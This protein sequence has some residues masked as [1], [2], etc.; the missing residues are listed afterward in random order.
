MLA[1]L[2]KAA[3]VNENEGCQSIRKADDGD[4]FIVG[5]VR[6][7]ENESATYHARRIVLALGNRGTP[8][9][10][11]VP[12]E[13]LKLKRD[14]A[15]R[16]K[17]QYKLI[18]PEAYRGQKILVVGAGNSAIEAAV[19]LVARRVGA[20]IIPR[21]PEETNK[22]TLLIRSD[23][24]NDLKLENKMQIY[25]CL[26]EGSI[27]S[28]FGTTIKEIRDGEVVL[29]NA[30]TGEVTKTIGNDYVFAMIGG[31]RPIKFLESIGIKL[32]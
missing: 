5:T 27:K 2:G 7:F 12:G 28:Y 18:S 10:L 8:M 24:K 19:D 26:D 30:R 16:D 13:N 9:K 21:S 32:G 1:R 11:K 23:F 25:D 31:D 20:R 29:M 15:E 14:D 22:V 17:V 6:G 3:T 4:Y